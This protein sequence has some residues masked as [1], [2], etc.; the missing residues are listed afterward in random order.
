MFDRE[1]PRPARFITHIKHQTGLK[2]TD[3]AHFEC[4]LVPIGD[5]DMVVEWYKDDVQLKHGTDT[6]LNNP[7]VLR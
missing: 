5:P 7:L 1:N 3:K 6:S 4:K 2:E